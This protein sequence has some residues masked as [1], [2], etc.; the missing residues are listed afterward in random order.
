VYA[1]GTRLLIA[2]L[3]EANHE[4]ISAVFD[5][6]LDVIEDAFE[7]RDTVVVKGALVDAGPDHYVRLEAAK[8]FVLIISSRWLLT[9]PASTANVPPGVR[10][11]NAWRR[12]ESRPGGGCAAFERSFAVINAGG[13]FT[14]VWSSVIPQLVEHRVGVR[15]EC[16][17]QAISHRGVRGQ[18]RALF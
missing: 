12:V 18:P 9:P 2:E 7:A 16:G 11:A 17:A 13:R 15:G 4:R 14:D 6:A 8:T 3:F 5:Q 10:A 1:P